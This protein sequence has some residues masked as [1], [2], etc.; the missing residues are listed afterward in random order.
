M[1]TEIP[2]DPA[3]DYE[4]ALFPMPEEWYGPPCPTCGYN[5]SCQDCQEEA[6]YN[7]WLDKRVAERGVELAMAP[8]TM[9]CYDCGRNP[10]WLLIPGRVQ[11]DIW[12]L[13]YVEQEVVA[14]GPIINKADPTQT[15][16]LKCGHMMF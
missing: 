14:L 10:L 5:F 2:D 6:A 15:Y 1:C 12:N 8:D 13:K 11:T 4:R 16:R 3:F 9:E 7:A